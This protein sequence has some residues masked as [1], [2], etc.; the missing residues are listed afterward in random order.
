MGQFT[1]SSKPIENKI[2][3]FMYNTSIDKK[4]QILL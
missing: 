4:V 2:E 1:S 3:F